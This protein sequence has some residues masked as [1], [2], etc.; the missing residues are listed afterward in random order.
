M[1]TKG[2]RRTASLW[3]LI[4]VCALLTGCGGGTTSGRSSSAASSKSTPS[5]TL[6]APRDTSTTEATQ[7]ETAEEEPAGEEAQFAGF[8]E[9]GTTVE[10]FTL[11]EV[12]EM[13]IMGAEIGWFSHEDSG[14]KLMYIHN[15][16]PDRAFDLTFL[17]HSIDN[18]GLPHV[19]E[20]ATLS[21]SQ[22]YPSK[23]LTFNLMYQTYTTFMN[24]MTYDRM[25]TYPI[26]SLSEAQLLALADFYTDSCFYPMIMEDESI[27]R[28]EAWRYRLAD[29]EAPLTIEGTVYSEM[30][31]AM[32]KSSWGYF[33][34]VR[35]SLPGSSIS[36]ESGGL[37]SAIPDMEWQDLKDYHDRFYRPENC[38]AFLYGNIV[39]YE[40]FLALLDGVFSAF[41]TPDA[42]AE[43]DAADSAET[44]ATAEADAADSAETDATAETDAADSAETDATAE[45]DA[46]DSA[47]TDASD[48]TPEE[49]EPAEE[50]WF[51]EPDYERITEAKTVEFPFAVEEGAQ[52]D[53]AS[54]VYY[55]F[56]CPDMT[57]EEKL[58][59]KLLLANLTMEGSPLS[60]TLKQELP[61]G[62]F[63]AGMEIAGPDM[64]PMFS[65]E[66]V[67]REEAARFKEIVDEALAVIVEEN[68]PEDL[69]ESVYATQALTNR[70]L[71]EGD[72]IGVNTIA[73]F[74]Y[75]YA[76]TG[77]PWNTLA[78]Y[79]SVEQMTEW[80]REGTFGA[81][82]EKYLVDNAL[83]TL[84]T[85]YPEP[86]LKEKEEEDLAKKL[87][88]VKAAMSEEEIAALVAETVAEDAE[89]AEGGEDAADEATTDAAAEAT[90]DAADEA[91]TDAAAEATTDAAAEATTDAAE[92]EEDETDAATDNLVK[93]LTAV[94]V[95]ELPEEVKEYE[96]R[97]ETSDDGVRF[98]ET[99][100]A[101]DGVG[102]AGIY[103]DMQSVT[104][105]EIHDMML[106]RNMT[107]Y[108]DTN[109][110]TRGE[111]ETLLTRY[112]YNFSLGISTIP[113]GE[114]KA[115]PYLSV[116]WIASDE[117]FAEG[118]ELVREILFDLKLDDTKKLAE[119]VTALR[120][121]RRANINNN[122]QLTARDR[123][124]ALHNETARFTEYMAGLDYYA[125]LEEIEKVLTGDDAAAVQEVVDR[126]TNI[127]E[128][129]KNRYGAVM[130]YA[131]SEEGIEK[132]RANVEEIFL[133]NVESSETEVTAWEIPAP[134]A[135]EAVIVESNV[136][137]NSV[138]ASNEAL[139]IEEYDAALEVLSQVVTD[140]ILLPELRD[141]YGVY[142]MFNWFTED[143][144]ALVLSYRDPN[145]DETFAV[146]EQLAEKV[147]ALE[148]DQETIDGYIMNT[149]VGYAKPAGELS[150]AFQA[151][152]ETLEEIPQDRKL[153]YMRQVKDVTPEVIAEKAELFEKL[154][155]TGMQQTT[156][157]AAK[158]NASADRYDEILNP[159]GATA[160][161]A[162]AGFEDVPE[163]HPYHREITMIVEQ[164][165]MSPLEENLFGPDEPAT[166]GDLAYMLMGGQ[167][168]A[169]TAL[170]TL[171]QALGV[172]NGAKTS[173]PLETKAMAE[174]LDALYEAQGAEP[175]DWE[176]FVEGDTVTR[177][178]LAYLALF[179]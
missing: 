28:E 37:P 176:S 163:D 5:V 53:N 125:Y 165:L 20:H 144:G 107:E 109:L 161:A 3:A 31:G 2:F 134:A 58:Q 22:K 67:D 87:E 115:H 121:A 173:D 30:L 51:E 154:L 82:A 66:N 25:T 151:L 10:G 110:H 29:A 52:T 142:S 118:Y 26:S 171:Q 127:Q 99:V 141:Q 60:Q 92:G 61:T 140:Q 122:P 15:D 159:F 96:V 131:G 54:I 35:E 149:Y 34:A 147:R 73:T 155:E 23:N 75:N 157:S 77:D 90:T 55:S 80:N 27:Y 146:Y 123:A 111:L 47:E 158:I 162:A 104:M 14:A 45:A 167:A 43:A 49:E 97:D 93:Q 48:E 70:L 11:L 177:G 129:L 94:T 50:V 32:T 106:F 135:K 85:T 105:E 17:T 65:I 174:A 101:V 1:K 98:L 150:G 170:A 130:L 59:M 153:T 148:L 119:S 136:C 138:T 62:T 133:A 36:F 7:E 13:P 145:I 164:G 100:A 63:S 46:A 40:K 41:E 117:E 137:F 68:L 108:L 33:N 126:L 8:P 81:L 112:T 172:M 114:Q 124:F 160:Q 143:R 18:T 16:D 156:G 88:E 9:T 4:L 21:G 24:A 91:T 168:D 132:N 72:Q 71:R 56:V 78:E 166:V 128:K 79:D 69:V 116:S 95:A 57:D 64:L 178:E 83:T 89:E 19:F 12:R 38:V 139:G 102:F 44:D 6:P 39:E 76:V 86:G 113:I 175:E 84:V 152:T 42:T 120:T 179:E 74:A 169:D 103:L